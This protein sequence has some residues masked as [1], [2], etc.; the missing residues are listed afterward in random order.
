MKPAEAARRVRRTCF[1]LA[2]AALVPL[3]AVSCRTGPT[4]AEPAKHAETKN[5]VAWG[6][7][8]DATFIS[9]ADPR[10][11]YEGRF[12]FSDTNAPVVIWQASRIHLGFEGDTV[13]LLFGP[14]Q[15]QCFF[16]ACVDD[17][18]RIVEIRAG[19]SGQKVDFS[20]LGTGRHRLVAA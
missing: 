14:P 20:G 8:P 18:T 15:G 17:S 12:D 2:V 4:A 10:F 19:A 3:L 16:N 5:A 13:S 9:A 1:R 6:S 11:L 7:D